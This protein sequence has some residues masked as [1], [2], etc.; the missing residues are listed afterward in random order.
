[1]YDI[2]PPGADNPS[3]NGVELSK[4]L[5]KTQIWEEMW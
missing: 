1:M 5:G 2:L 4:L 3:Y